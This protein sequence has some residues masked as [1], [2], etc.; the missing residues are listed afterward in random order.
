MQGAVIR[1]DNDALI[2]G[3]LDA[4]SLALLKL[5]VLDVGQGG[6]VVD[7]FDV[8]MGGVKAVVQARDTFEVFL[9]C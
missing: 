9:D 3:K 7:G 4:D 2:V 1:Q 8:N 5:A 6:N